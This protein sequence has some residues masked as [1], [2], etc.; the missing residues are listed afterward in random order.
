VADVEHFHALL[1][2]QYVVYHTINMGF[3][4]VKQV[5]ELVTLARDRAAIR[6]L[7]QAENAHFEAPVPFQSC[8]GIFR[9]D[10]PVQP[11]KVALGSGRDVN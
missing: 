10:L 4:A 1:F 2:L 5:P 6:M 7:F 11:G 9:I 8:L 3:G